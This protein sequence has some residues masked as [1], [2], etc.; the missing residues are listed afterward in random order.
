[1]YWLTSNVFTASQIMFFKTPAVRKFFNIPQLINH[2]K[3]KVAAKQPGFMES[4]KASYEGG[5][6][7]KQKELAI[8]KDR[9]NKVA[10]QKLRRQNR[11]RI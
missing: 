4:F 10:A 1:M 5:L 9:E 8:A 7:A 11:K 6:A 2:P 3:P